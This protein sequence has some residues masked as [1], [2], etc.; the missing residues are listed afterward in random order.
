MQSVVSSSPSFCR[1]SQE[2]TVGRIG[3]VSRIYNTVR[4]SRAVKCHVVSCGH[5]TS[6][7]H[8]TV[9][10]RSCDTVMLSRL[11]PRTQTNSCFFC[12]FLFY[13]TSCY[14]YF[15][16]RIHSFIL[17][18]TCSTQSKKSLTRMGL[19]FQHQHNENQQSYLSGHI[20]S[21]L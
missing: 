11:H 19:R 3:K 20:V 17:F 7:R 16:F 9:H 10:M 18:T 13:P 8:V 14:R 6:H 15:H 1:Q 12:F 4:A 5:L 2:S 21:Y